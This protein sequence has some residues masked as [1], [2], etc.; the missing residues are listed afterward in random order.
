MH[1]MHMGPLEQT[2]PTIDTMGGQVQF[3]PIL[4]NITPVFGSWT[5]LDKK[6][7][8]KLDIIGQKLGK[9]LELFST[10][11]TDFFEKK[12]GQNWT[13]FRKNFIPF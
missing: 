4:S 13:K 10:S 6:S 1:T 8:T 2:K 11:P 9:F 5:K 12:V 7:W 3:C